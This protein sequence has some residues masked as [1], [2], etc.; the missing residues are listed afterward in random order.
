MMGGTH[1]LAFL[2]AEEKGMPSSHGRLFGFTYMPGSAQTTSEEVFHAV[3]GREGL[4]IDL[5]GWAAA[6]V[7]LRT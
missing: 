2:F 4:G 1:C 3:T 6:L 5:G 7:M